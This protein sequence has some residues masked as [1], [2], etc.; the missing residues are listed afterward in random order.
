MSAMKEYEMSYKDELL[1]IYSDMYKDLNGFRPR[2]G[3]FDHVNDMDVEELKALM[4]RMSDMI[5]EQIDRERAYRDAYK[6]ELAAAEA[7]PRGFVW[8]GD[9]DYEADTTKHGYVL[10]EVPPND[11]MARAFAEARV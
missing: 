9:Y 5:G 2:G 1:G 3:A 6:A 8:K 10:P 4:H 11:A 7:S